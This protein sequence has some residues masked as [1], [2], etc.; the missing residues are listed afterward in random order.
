MTTAQR[1]NFILFITDQQRADH[2][3]A[4]GNAVVRTPHLDTLT[5]RGWRANNCFVAS[6]ICM[7]NRASLLTG[8]LPSVHG[9]R[10]NGVAL[11]LNSR[12]F[13]ERL[14]EGGYHTRLI[15]KSHLQNI[16]DTR[17]QYPTGADAA[18]DGEARRTS[19]GRLDQECG[20]LWD[21]DPAF[22]VDLPFYGF[23]QVR[24]EQLELGRQVRAL[25]ERLGYA[26]RGG[27]WRA[28]QGRMA[29]FVG[30]LMLDDGPGRTIEAGGDPRREVAGGH[31]AGR[32][33]HGHDQ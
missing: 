2:V 26:Q 33:E 9:A 30:D 28:P 6:P 16:T 10:H 1:P 25:L 21:E 8:R 19:P 22:D 14:R 3:G 5:A 4:Y 7:P 17:A 24:Q 27:H 31:R 23:E 18:F 20:P 32:A 29:V 12:T 15:G 11:P 13:V